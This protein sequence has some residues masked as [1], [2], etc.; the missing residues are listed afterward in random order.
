MSQLN[1]NSFPVDTTS[2]E[3]LSTWIFENIRPFLQDRILEINSSN[4][5]FSTMLL[6]DGFTIQLNAKSEDHRQ[7]LRDTFKDSTLVRGIHK[8]NFSNPRMEIKYREFQH[9]FSTVIAFHDFAEDVFYEKPSL[10]KAKRFL[11]PGGHI[12]I[13]AQAEND[14]FPGAEP[15]LGYLRKHNRKWINS[16]LSDCEVRRLRFFNWK[17]LCFIAIGRKSS[18]EI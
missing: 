8:I 5:Y 10:D 13:A 9:Q 15:D 17:G 18:T 16:L 2:L 3:S 1:I 7:F 6:N 14:L 11:R 12:I 4:E